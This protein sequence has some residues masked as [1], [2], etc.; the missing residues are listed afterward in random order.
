MPH[1]TPRHGIHLAVEPLSGD[2]AGA[3]IGALRTGESPIV[4]ARE[5]HAVEGA[6]HG[7]GRLRRYRGPDPGLKRH[8][9][10][11]AVVVHV[12]L[13]DAVVLA[14]VR[15]LHLTLLVD[16]E[17]VGAVRV[18]GH[19][20]LNVPVIGP[21][22]RG[23]RLHVEDVRETIRSEQH[24]ARGIEQAAGHPNELEG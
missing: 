20:D 5:A 1:P 4:P 13:D 14:K 3:A 17:V 18:V 15:L 21:R 12:R 2:R 10:A 8:A 16:E 11:C 9:D 23:G 24:C 6:G 19:G 7:V 22:P